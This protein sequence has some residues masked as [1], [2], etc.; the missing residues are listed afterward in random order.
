MP[1]KKAAKKALRS[2]RKKYEHNQ[3]IKK[4]L[5][6]AIKKTDEKN[7]GTTFSM[8]DKAAKKNV[9]HKN[10]ASRLKS[11]LAKKV[12]NTPKAEKTTKAAVPARP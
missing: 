2:S 7:I 11:R 6:K 10:K 5:K 12:G 8:L 3:E 1:I 4:S 9:I